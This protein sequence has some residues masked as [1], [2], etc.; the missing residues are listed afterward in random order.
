MSA[1]QDHIPTEDGQFDDAPEDVTTLEPVDARAQV[2]HPLIDEEELLEWSSDSTEDGD[3]PDEFENEE[4]ELESAAF[5]D[6]RAEDEDWE[7]AERG[8]HNM[9]FQS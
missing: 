7:I 2:T 9:L 8:M 5:E 6:L 3:E 4:D 1:V